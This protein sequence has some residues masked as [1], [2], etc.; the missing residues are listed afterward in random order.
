VWT[1][2]IPGVLSI[3]PPPCI[4]VYYFGHQEIEVEEKREEK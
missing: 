2:G 4:A 3:V 1:T